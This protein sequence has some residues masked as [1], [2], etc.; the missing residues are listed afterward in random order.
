MRR[1]KSKVEA[2]RRIRDIV[3][4]P[5][6]LASGRTIEVTP[7]WALFLD[8][9]GTLLPIAET[10]D[11]VA[12]SVRLC[13]A[14]RDVVPALDGAVALISGRPIAG[15][16][17]LFAPLR[18]PS[19]GLHGLERR[20]AAGTL[21]KAEGAVD[22][23][24]LRDSLRAFAD[25]H[26]GVLLEDKGPALALHYRRAPAAEAAARQLVSDMAETIQGRV[27]I[28]FGKMVIEIASPLADKGM[29]IAAFMEEAPFAGRRPVFI[30]DDVTDEDGFAMVNGLGG[31]TIRVGAAAAST[32]AY[33]FPDVNSVVD[34]LQALPAMLRSPPAG[35]PA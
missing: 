23:S 28:L 34:W 11:A 30:G 33:Q 24:D 27:R 4:L 7:D 6:Q 10:P 31:Y 18:L 13:E 17:R 15:L 9:D 29:A 22:L 12:V 2:T 16:D 20:D 3:P 14:L 8:V 25:A 19:A 35:E 26:P 5:R 1:V 21:H 32:A